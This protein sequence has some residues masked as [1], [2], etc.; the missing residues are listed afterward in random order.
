MGFSFAVVFWAWLTTPYLKIGR[1]TFALTLTDRSSGQ[2]PDSGEGAPAQLSA[3][4][5]PGPVG[6]GAPAQL[7]ANHYPGPV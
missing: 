3:N 6:E 2:D 7:S 1:R 5:Y 4:H